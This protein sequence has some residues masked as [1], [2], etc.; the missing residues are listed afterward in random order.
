MLWNFPELAAATGAIRVAASL[1]IAGRTG[2]GDASNPGPITFDP[3]LRERVVCPE[4]TG[5][6]G[7]LCGSP[8]GR[9]AW[10]TAGAPLP[11]GRR[12][13]PSGAAPG[14]SLW[15]TATPLA[16]GRGGGPEDHRENRGPMH[17]G[18]A[19]GS[20]PVGSASGDC[21]SQRHVYP[22]RQTRRHPGRRRRSHRLDRNR[23]SRVRLVRSAHDRPLQDLVE[24]LPNWEADHPSSFFGHAQSIGRQGG[25][26]GVRP[27]RGHFRR[28]G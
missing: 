10:S 19:T 15:R 9:S 18:V 24:H 12:A 17:P 23:D 27:R 28:P 25:P 11:I 26:A 4:C 2:P 8:I 16:S 21:S 5:C 3:S 22:D 6:A 1:G 13:T 7:R 20:R 14:K